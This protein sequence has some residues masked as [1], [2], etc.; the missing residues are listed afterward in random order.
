MQ[1]NSWFAA[2][3]IMATILKER[4]QK[5][6]ILKQQLYLE[7]VFPQHGRHVFVLQISRDWLQTTNFTK[8]LAKT[9]TIHIKNHH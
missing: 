9:I 3:D 5:N 7:R 6:L 8:C 2:V 4:W 1:H